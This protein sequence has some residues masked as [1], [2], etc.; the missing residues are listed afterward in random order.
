MAEGAGRSSGGGGGGGGEKRPR[1]DEDAAAG[2]LGLSELVGCNIK[3]FLDAE[4]LLVYV[5]RHTYISDTT[6]QEGMGHH[7][8]VPAAIPG[9]VRVCSSAQS[10]R[11]AFRE[12]LGAHVFA[13]STS[14]ARDDPA[15]T[16][17]GFYRAP[18]EDGG[19]LWKHIGAA[20]AGEAEAAVGRLLS[21]EP[22]AERCFRFP[23]TESWAESGC[24][25]LHLGDVLYDDFAT[26]VECETLQDAREGGPWYEDPCRSSTI[27]PLTL[28]DDQALSA[29]QAF[30]AAAPGIAAAAAEVI[31]L[32][33]LAARGRAR[34]IGD[35]GAPTTS[36]MSCGTRGIYVSQH[37]EGQVQDYGDF[38]GHFFSVTRQVVV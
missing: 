23:W 19:S 25:S 37:E 2:A 20:E 28:A 18:L 30:V 29:R 35:C 11:A 17:N 8:F 9:T 13:G 34:C 16:W 6:Y 31:R 33:D 38:C 4:G 15:S 1:K 7:A 5:V 26:C 12:L 21:G 14:I 24:I 22:D 36:G 3:R 10:A 27:G 32:A